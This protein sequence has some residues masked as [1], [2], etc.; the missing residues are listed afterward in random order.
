M[1]GIYLQYRY[2]LLDNTPA[3]IVELI[4]LQL[5]WLLILEGKHHHIMGRVPMHDDILRDQLW[6]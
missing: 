3:L 6:F 1:G 5:D 2:K 4:L